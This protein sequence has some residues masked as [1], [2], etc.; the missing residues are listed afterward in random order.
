MFT[1][2]LFVFLLMRC[3]VLIVDEHSLLLMWYL[4]Q[5]MRTDHPSNHAWTVPQGMEFLFIC[6]LYFALRGTS[7]G[8]YVV[9]I[10]Y[11]L[12]LIVLFF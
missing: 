3:S 6:Y 12:L 2:Y 5:R 8:V 10:C 9:Q 4:G 7:T 11:F 1:W